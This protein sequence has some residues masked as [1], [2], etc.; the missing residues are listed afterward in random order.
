MELLL[1]VLLEE[2]EAELRRVALDPAITSNRGRRSAPDARGAGDQFPPESGRRPGAE[3]RRNPA[4]HPD[5][6][7]WTDRLSPSRA[8]GQGAP[9]PGDHNASAWQDPMSGNGPRAQ[10]MQHPMARGHADL[11]QSTTRP[12]PLATM[13]ADYDSHPADMRGM[14]PGI[15]IA[16]E[17]LDAQAASGLG[18]PPA[19]PFARLAPHIAPINTGGPNGGHSLVSPTST[20]PLAAKSTGPLTGIRAIE[21]LKHYGRGGAR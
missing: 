5:G 2:I 19:N 1:E 21:A 13:R 9:S 12:F 3:G 6:G 18:G 7:S 16:L 8:S 17:R 20:P 4:P 11:Q 15:P 14:T 10:F